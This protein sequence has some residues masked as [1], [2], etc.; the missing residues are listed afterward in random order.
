MWKGRKKGGDVGQAC[1]NRVFVSRRAVSILG[2]IHNVRSIHATRCV[3]SWRRSTWNPSHPMDN[4]KHEADGCAYGN[5]VALES[6]PFRRYRCHSTRCKER[7][8][9]RKGQRIRI[10]VGA[11]AKRDDGATPRPSEAVVSE[12]VVVSRRPMELVQRWLGMTDEEADTVLEKSVDAG[13]ED[14]RPPRLGLGAKFLSHNK[15]RIR[16]N[17]RFQGGETEEA[18]SKAVL[19]S[20]SHERRRLRSCPPFNAGWR[21]MS[22]WPR[23]SLNKKPKKQNYRHK[24]LPRKRRRKEG[25]SMPWKARGTR[26]PPP[27]SKLCCMVHRAARR[28]DVDDDSARLNSLDLHRSK[29][30]F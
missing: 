7:I 28:S 19:T 29:V 23:K 18:P 16:R 30:Y 25:E 3:S 5:H 13:L 2:N 11:M 22:G 8:P 9:I 17:A 1:L 20:D 6:M 24:T 27:N 15:V 21:R 26:G 4:D 14:S 10:R 12:D